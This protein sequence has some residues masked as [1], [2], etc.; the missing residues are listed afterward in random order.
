MLTVKDKQIILNVNI[1]KELSLENIA[2]SR[3]W[4]VTGG[5]PDIARASQYML[6]D[7]RDGKIGKFILDNIEDVNEDLIL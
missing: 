4:V 5:E 1:D 3:N 6:K 2:I 7:F